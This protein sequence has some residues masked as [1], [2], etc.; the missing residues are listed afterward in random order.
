MKNQKNYHENYINIRTAI[1]L[2]FYD[3]SLTTKDQLNEEFVDNIINALEEIFK[4]RIKE[5]NLKK[6]FYEEAMLDDELDHK[7]KIR[8]YYNI[9]E[10]NI[11]FH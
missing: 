7:T 10:L 5:D 1:N 8:K 2:L 6:V 9:K 3:L 11:L 4:Y